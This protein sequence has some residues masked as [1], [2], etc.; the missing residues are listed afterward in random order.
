[1]TLLSL[2]SA[3]RIKELSILVWIHIRLV[4]QEI[5]KQEQRE[6]CCAYIYTIAL[7][8]LKVHHPNTLSITSPKSK[9]LQRKQIKEEGLEEKK[10][11]GLIFA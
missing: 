8:K 6:G 4:D 1:L 11:K 9:H 10:P 3:P 2:L 5:V 7:L